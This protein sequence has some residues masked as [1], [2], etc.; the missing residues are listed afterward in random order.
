MGENIAATLRF[1]KPLWVPGMYLMGFM[2][3]KPIPNG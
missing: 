3:F 2:A 1:D